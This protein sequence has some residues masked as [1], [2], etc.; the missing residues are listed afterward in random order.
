[1]GDNVGVPRTDP[2]PH[3]AAGVAEA[4]GDAIGSRRDAMSNPNAT[5]IAAAATELR[6]GGLVAF[7]TETVYG[8]GADASNRE[9]VRRIF[10]VKGR[11]TSHPLIVHFADRIE[12]DRFAEDVPELARRLAEA[13]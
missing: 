1:M 13:F 8:L 5:E 10:E 6:R 3:P 9:A 7:P 12:L 4:L 11:P 2:A